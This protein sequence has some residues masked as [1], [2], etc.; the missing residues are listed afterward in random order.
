[1]KR[2]EKQQLED[3]TEAIARRIA[4]EAGASEALWEFFLSA[5]YAEVFPHAQEVTK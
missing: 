1:M 5:A 4:R 3:K 2:T